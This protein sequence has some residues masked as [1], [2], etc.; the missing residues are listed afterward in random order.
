MNFDVAITAL[1]VFSF[2]LESH[3]AKLSELKYLF[4]KEGAIGL[5]PYERT[6][7]YLYLG[8]NYSET[9]EKP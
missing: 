5:K 3:K 1:C 6:L 7:I 4:N 9:Y 8:Y 2:R